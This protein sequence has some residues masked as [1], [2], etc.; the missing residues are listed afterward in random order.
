M[1]RAWGTRVG[2]HNFGAVEVYNIVVTVTDSGGLSD[3]DSLMAVVYDPSAGFVTGRGWIDSPPG[4]YIPDPALTGKANIGFVSKSRKGRHVQAG[5]T[6]IQSHTGD[7]DFYSSSYEWLVVTGSNC[8]RFK[9]SGTINGMGDYRL[10]FWAGDDDPDTFRIKM[11]EEEDL[12]Y[13]TVIHD[14]GSVQAIGGGSIV[15]H[16]KKQ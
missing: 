1:P 10:Q 11:C 14:N 12:G 13:E 3:S 15:I 6:T 8:G 7:L 4:A 16:T 2:T 5:N 9:G